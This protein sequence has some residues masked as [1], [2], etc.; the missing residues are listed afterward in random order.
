MKRYTGVRVLTQAL[1]DPDV[2]ILIG[3]GIVREAQPYLNQ[4]SHL[5]FDGEED[6]LLSMALGMSMC[7]DKRVF[8]F[9]EEQYFTRNLSEFLQIGISK[10]R[11]FYVVLFVNGSYSCVPNTPT[12]F[13]SVSN[14]H[15]VLFNM[16]FIVHDYKGQFK[17]K[18]N[19][20]KTIKQFLERAKGPLAILLPTEHYNKKFPEVPMSTKD[21]IELTK[22]FIMDKNIE[23][24]NFVVPFSLYKE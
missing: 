10:C 20:T 7:T 5:F 15:G 14:Q 16:G 17:L 8:V 11:N 22:K 6:Y 2:A 19:P 4:G 9:C 24:H 13:G 1:K 12:P 23:A 3:E 18:K 21:S